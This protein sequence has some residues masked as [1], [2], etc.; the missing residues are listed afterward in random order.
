[1]QMKIR[2]VLLLEDVTKI[3]TPTFKAILTPDVRLLDKIFKDGGFKLRIVGGA[4][5]DLLLNKE[6][7]DIDFATDAT[8]EQMVKLGEDYVKSR[9]GVGT[10]GAENFRT[11]PSAYELR[12]SPAKVAE[13]GSWKHGTVPFIIN[14]E[15]YEI[16]TLRI[17]VETYGRH[18]KV[19]YTRD[20]EQDAARR[21]LTINAMSL[22]LDGN[23]YDYFGG[24][25]DLK[26]GVIRFV[27]SAE[28]R[29]KED[30]LRIL[31]Y[32]RFQGR[33]PETQWPEGTREAI[34]ANAAGLKQISGERIWAEI[35]QILASDKAAAIV[36]D[37]CELGVAPYCSI[38]CKNIDYLAQTT[39]FSKNPITR[40]SALFDNEQEVDAAA[41]HLKWSI[42]ERDLAVFLVNHKSKKIDM[43]GA[44]ELV[45]HKVPK[46]F[47]AELA[48]LQ[49]NGK[50]A[51]EILS[52]QPAQFPITGN[53]LIKAGVKPGPQMGRIL[54]QLKDMWIKSHYKLSKEELLQKLGGRE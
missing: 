3:N 32:F 23:L 12:D 15:M 9:G 51:H 28:Q 36:K 30:Y 6:P 37:M 10:V 25:E 41:A 52:W 49:H 18:A 24:K 20:F 45:L 13:L 48:A 50:V 46:E 16:T 26:N 21:D 42:P 8:P 19:A 39:G 38:P 5:R 4:V 29:I 54:A 35:K 43:D 47:V 7:K 40:L 34:K 2:D 27:G 17:D 31:R 22:D 11:I 33:F 14:G 53:D 44:E 1:M